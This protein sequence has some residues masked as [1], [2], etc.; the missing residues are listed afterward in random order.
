[1]QSESFHF[2]VKFTVDRRPIYIDVTFTWFIHISVELSLMYPIAKI[3]RRYSGGQDTGLIY[4]A[5][6]KLIEEMH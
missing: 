3:I 5:E 6:M 4:T 2:D 1:V